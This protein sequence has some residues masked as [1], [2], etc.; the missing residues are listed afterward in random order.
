MYTA[1]KYYEP[2]TYRTAYFLLKLKGREYLIKDFFEK[3][4][5]AAVSV[6]GVRNLGVEYVSALK[7]AKVQIN[8]IIDR[9]YCSYTDGI[10]GIPVFGLQEYCEKKYNDIVIVTPVKFFNNI[11][12][13]LKK[14]GISE[15]HILHAD[16]MVFSVFWENQ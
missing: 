9:N 1:Q 4:N 7:V 3:R 11:V 16:D 13:D 5:I 10:E 12:F 6:Y 14:S 2:E 15:S 8:C